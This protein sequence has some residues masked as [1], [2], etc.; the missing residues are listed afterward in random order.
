MVL[1]PTTPCVTFNLSPHHINKDSTNWHQGH[2]PNNR[3]A[4]PVNPLAVMRIGVLNCTFPLAVINTDTTSSAFLV[5]NP[6]LPTGHM[7]T[8]VFH[9][10]NGAFTPTTTIN[11][12]HHEVR[13]SSHKVN[14]AP[15]LV[16]HSLLNTRKFAAVGYAAIYDKDEVNFYNT[17][18][19]MITVSTDTVLVCYFPGGT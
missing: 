19:T 9:L 11:Q 3:T 12:I 13:V 14:F 8:G 10:P 6:S 5:L 18:T 2:P 7:S 1:P 4:Y 17:R 16:D 15:S